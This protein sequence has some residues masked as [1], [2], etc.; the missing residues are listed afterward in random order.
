MTNEMRPTA[1]RPPPRAAPGCPYV[2]LVPFGE[3]GEAV[4]LR[5]GAERDLIVANLTAARLTLLYAA[6]GVGKS[7]VLRAGRPAAATPAGRRVVRGSRSSPAA[8]DRLTSATG[9][10][11]PSKRIGGGD[12]RRSPP[13]E[14]GAQAPAGLRA[15]LDARLARGRSSTVGGG[16]RS[17]SILDQF[18]EYFLYHPDDRGADGAGRGLG[19]VLSA[20]DLRRK[21][22]AVYTRGRPRRPGPLQGPHPA[23]VRQ[24][25]TLRTLDRAAARNAIEGPLAQ[26]NASASRPD[27][28]GMTIDPQLIDRLLDQVQVG[29]CGG[30]QAVVRPGRRARATVEPQQAAR[31]RADRGAVPPVGAGPDCG[32]RN[33][34]AV[35]GAAS[36]HSGPLGGSQPSSAATWTT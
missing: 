16:V 13:A 23:P 21:R 3:G 18:E 15:R 12:R 36:R 9:V 35:G 10:A 8:A 33:R 4:L 24:L 29:R 11:D 26:Y 17:T 5:P 19:D 30:G 14:R 6:S 31:A 34:S 28:S 32:T 7:S 22:P 20:R 25:P 27:R 1:A 2:G